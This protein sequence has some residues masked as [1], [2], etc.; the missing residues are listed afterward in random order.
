MK[1]IEAKEDKVI[2]IIGGMGP[3]ATVDLFLK[4]IQNTE[5]TTDQEHLRLLIDSNGKIPDRIEAIFKNGEN[6]GPVMAE[7]ARN[8]EKGGADLLAIACNTAHY[9]YSFVEKAVNIPVLHMPKLAVEQIC[10]L[11]PETKKI[12]LLATTAAVKIGLYQ[13]II[14]DYGCEVIIP[15]TDEQQARVQNSI[16]QIKAGLKAEPER[17][18]KEVAENLILAGADVVLTGCTEISMVL[19]EGSLSVPVIDPTI[20]LAK[21]IIAL[22]KAK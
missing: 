9:F 8:L 14:A 6:P 15:A 21:E 5:A 17:T 18:V 10:N 19:K 16:Y 11:Y 20:V 3:E 12:G 22:G 1:G 13:N 4:I 7:M 2:G